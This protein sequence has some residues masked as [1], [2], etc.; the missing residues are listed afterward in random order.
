MTFR[1]RVTGRSIAS[2]VFRLDGRVI[3]RVS[4]AQVR[5]SVRVRAQ[6]LA[7]GRHRVLARVTFVSASQ[8]RPRTLRMTFRRCARSQVSPRFTG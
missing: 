4:R 3:R 6:R 7:L 5:Y 2:V 8:T 1:A